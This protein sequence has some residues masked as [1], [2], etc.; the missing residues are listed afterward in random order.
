MEPR[1]HY[2]IRFPHPE[3]HVYELTLTVTDAEPGLHELE[4]AVWTPGSYFVREFEGHVHRLR[5]E[6]LGGEP[7]EIA[8]IRKNGWA[9]EAGAGFRVH[10][11]VYANE[12]TVDTSHLDASH[13]YWNGASLF[14]AVDGN[15][16]LPVTLDIQAPRGWRVATGLDIQ[17]Q[18]EDGH[19]RLFAA[20]Y[21]TLLDGPVE[22]GTHRSYHF[23]VLGKDHELA[24]WGHGNEDPERLTQDLAKIVETSAAIFGG[25]PYD[26]Y[27]FILHLTDHR[28]GG[29]EHKNSTTCQTDRWSY[30]PE[31]S[32]LGVLTLFS[33]EFFHLWN[34][35]RIH[36]IALGPF[37]YGVENH[38]TLLWAMEGI[39][40]Y[41]AS[42]LLAR[43][44]LWSSR[45]YRQM[46]AAQIRNY[47]GTPGRNVQ[48]A[49][50]SSYD[51][52]VKFYR[53]NESSP[54]FTISYYIKGSLIGLCLDLEIRNRTGGKR[55]LD[56]VLRAL[57]ET[58]GQHD[59]GFEEGVY[60]KTAED[61]VGGSLEPFWK[62]YVEGVDNLDPGEYLR[63]AGLLLTRRISA[64]ERLKDAA[65]GSDGAVEAAGEGTQDLDA[66]ESEGQPRSSLGLTLDTREGRLRV[67]SVLADRSAWRAG[68]NSADELVAMDGYRIVSEAFL[69]D[70]LSER[71]P[72]SDVRLTVNRAGEIRDFTVRLDEAAPDDYRIE[73]TEADEAQR[74]VYDTWLGRSYP[75]GKTGAASASKITDPPTG[76]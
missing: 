73:L 64:D 47:E 26:R 34:V 17:S 72:G 30:R 75:A 63:Y 76:F 43:A 21:D 4:M 74:R 3:T 16:S 35:K 68:V 66:L 65:N 56:D 61:A 31:K 32:Y 51:T 15:K 53:R 42:L 20:D 12:L 5:A 25:L 54:N 38:T 71:A 67:N 19:I 46:L 50:Q 29:L 59:Q 39:T 11:E 60:R 70:R 28:G 22:I 36:P 9:V 49:A 2:D 8:K 69:R 1:V 52:W 23:D 14:F 18:G 55:G 37:D 45:K 48:S 6:G 13:A 27:V 44:G 41:Y 62:A 57:W 7:L 10:Y 24:M 33:H 40:D 58:Y